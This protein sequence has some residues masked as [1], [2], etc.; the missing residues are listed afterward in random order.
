VNRISTSCPD[1][2]APQPRVAVVVPCCNEEPSIERLAAALD[3]LEAQ[4]AGQYDLELVLVDDGST[5]RTWK[6]LQSRFANRSNARLVQHEQNRGIAAAIATGIAAASADVVASI[7]A[8]CTYD[9]ALL[10]QMLPLLTSEVDLVV[11]SPYHPR[12]AVQNVPAWRLALSKLASRMYGC[13]L[14]NKLHTYTSCFR[15]YRR[16]AVVD[17]PLTNRGFVGVAELVWRL[18]ALGSTIVECPALLEVRRTGHS[19]LKVVRATLGHLRL[20]ARAAWHRLLRPL[21]HKPTATM[22]V[23]TSPSPV[24]AASEVSETL[25]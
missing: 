5:D 24:L 21:P 1:E 16:A 25:A 20:L 19:K 9:P 7:D 17:L 22:T 3:R 2:F 11:A 15:V 10:A 12:G 23:R 6:A 18:D 14:R 4:L 13:V 8:D